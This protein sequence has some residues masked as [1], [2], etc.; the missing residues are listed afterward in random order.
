MH[1]LDFRDLWCNEKNLRYLSQVSSHNASHDSYSGN[2]E[3]K[4]KNKN[5][6]FPEM[7]MARKIF[8]RANAN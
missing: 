6:L 3:A 2:A 4:T 1:K 7:P 8:T 5:T